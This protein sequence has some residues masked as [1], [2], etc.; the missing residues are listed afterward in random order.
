MKRW[1]VYDRFFWGLVI[2]AVILSIIGILYD[3]HAEE[4]TATVCR[5]VDGQF[6]FH[7]PA[8][9][10]DPDKASWWA[11]GDGLSMLDE[12]TV[13]LDP[14]T[15]VEIYGEGFPQWE[16]DLRVGQALVGSGDY[17]IILVGDINSSSC[18]VEDTPVTISEPPEP[19]PGDEPQTTVSPVAVTSTGRTC[20]VKYPEII[21]VCNG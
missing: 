2:L 10:N 15:S 19:M 8:S 13:L 7:I 4:D 11:L 6:R 12:T 20:T 3:V 21:L 5:T 17:S 14:L 1:D 18:D 9:W 16:Q